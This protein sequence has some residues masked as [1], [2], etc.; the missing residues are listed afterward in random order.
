MIS[1]I[2]DAKNDHARTPRRKEKD[3]A[4]G[5]WTTVIQLLKLGNDDS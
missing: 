5:L 3:V 4:I 1:Y 2:C